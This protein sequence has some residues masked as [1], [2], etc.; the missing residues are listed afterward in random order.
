LI[1]H[2]I[3]R[4]TLALLVG[5]I[6]VPHARST[7]VSRVLDNYNWPKSWPYS[8]DDFIPEDASDDQL[9]YVVPKVSFM[10]INISIKLNI[11]FLFAFLT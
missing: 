9:F 7:S 4:P 5:G 1:L 3:V 10:S 2:L 8:D 6:S 11:L